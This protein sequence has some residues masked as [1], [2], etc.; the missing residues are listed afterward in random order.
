MH[1]TSGILIFGLSFLLSFFSISVSAQKIDLEKKAEIIEEGYLMFRL[2]LA[3]W[4]STDRLRDYLRGPQVRALA[5]YLSYSDEDSLRS[6]Y[7]TAG[8]APQILAT[9]S[10]DRDGSPGSLVVDSTARQATQTELL[11]IQLREAALRNAQNDQTDFYVMYENTGINLVVLPGEKRHKVY[12]MTAPQ[13]EGVVLMGNDYLLEFDENIQLIS[14]KKLHAGLIEMK[15]GTE[16]GAKGELIT[17]HEHQKGE[18]DYITSTDLCT[19]LLYSQL[20]DWVAHHVLSPK[21]VSVWDIESEQ[22]LI[23][24]QKGFKKIVK[25]N[26]KH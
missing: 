5:G 2:E 15:L 4:Q 16:S 10:F 20:T 23:L 18:S 14:R 13:V 11:Y 25:E 6:I 8:D 19:L 17:A 24:T 7:Y 1:R 26:E 21:F 3:S 12:F 9:V 22:M